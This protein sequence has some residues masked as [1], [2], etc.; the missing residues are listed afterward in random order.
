VQLL[1][2]GLDDDD[3]RALA[4]DPV[5]AIPELFEVSVQVR[6]E[7]GEEI[8]SVHGSYFG[9]DQPISVRQA[10][11]VARIRF[12]ALHE[13]GHHL[14]DVGDHRIDLISG[15]NHR[16]L[17]EA[18]CDE[19]A[20]EILVPDAVVDHWISAEGPTAR[21]VIDLYHDDRVRASRAACCVAAAKKIVGSGY[22]ML[23]D[24]SGV[25]RFTAVHGTPYRVAGDTPQGDDS[26]P[27]KAARIGN[28]RDSGRVTYRS[29]GYS[30]HHHADAR[31]DGEYVFTVFTTGPPPWGG[32]SLLRRPEWQPDE[33]Q[34]DRCGED[35]LPRDWCDHDPRR[36]VCP[37]CGA[38]SC[39]ARVS[40]YQTCLGCYLQFATHLLD[41]SGLCETCH[42]S[43]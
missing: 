15:P 23:S 10:L 4:R 13:L 42:A 2:A 40:Q 37:S 1:L 8:C 34:C 29:G 41:D 39:G 18:I 9:S 35:F 30:D 21:A 25:A 31:L 26:I 27:A 20:A 24:L 22:V 5:S 14:L 17:E 12:S 33:A 11:S 6:P 43:I 32:L 7:L 19:F 16:D 36:P 28:K 3:L 38:C